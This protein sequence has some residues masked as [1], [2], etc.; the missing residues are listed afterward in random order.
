MFFVL[1]VFQCVFK[2]GR[3]TTQVSDFE[4]KSYKLNLK[5]LIISVERRKTLVLSTTLP[6]HT[7]ASL[8]I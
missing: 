4:Q 6:S 7:I 5:C 8:R 2:I 1:V 3:Q